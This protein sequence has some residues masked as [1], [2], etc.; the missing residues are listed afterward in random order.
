MAFSGGEKNRSLASRTVPPL[1]AAAR[2]TVSPAQRRGSGTTSPSTRSRATPPSGWI[3][4]RR[5]VASVGGISM[6]FPV[7]PSSFCRSAFIRQ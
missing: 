6:T 7:P 4:R 3:V 2:S 1:S 5:W